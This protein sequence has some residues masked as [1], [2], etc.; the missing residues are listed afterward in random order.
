LS[1]YEK[2]SWYYDKT[3]ALIRQHLGLFDEHIEITTEDLNDASTRLAIASFVG[4]TNTLLPPKFHLNASIIDISSFPKQ[5]RQRMNWLMG[6]LNIE[7]IAADEVYALDYFLDKF[8]AWK[9]Y[10]IVDS[11]GSEAAPAGKITADLERA[12]KLIGGRLRSIEVLQQ[13][14]RGR[15]EKN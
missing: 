6:R 9:G 2:C 10:Q 4:G 8:I 5:Q 12:A 14:I 11:P 7:E 15:N 3:H 1:I 13:L